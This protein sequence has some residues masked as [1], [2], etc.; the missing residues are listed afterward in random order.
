MAAF[1]QKV[2]RFALSELYPLLVFLSA[3]ACVVLERQDVG[4]CVLVA[5]IAPV[6]FF[7]DDVLPV[8]FPFLILVLLCFVNADQSQALPS[9]VYALVPIVV[10]MIALPIIRA[11]RRLSFGVCFPGL[12]AISVALVLGGIGSITAE[13][14]F[15]L[16]SLYHI[17][18]LGALMIVAYLFVKAAATYERDY[19]A[20]DKIAL[21]SY[22][23]LVFVAFMILRVFTYPDVWEGNIDMTW[24]VVA[25]APWRNSTAALVVTLLPFVFYYA[26][27]HHPIH[28]LCAFLIYVI[29]A[30]SGS[31]GALLCGG[32]Q[33]VLC[34]VFFYL[35]KGT[36]RRVWTWLLASLTVVLLL[37]FAFRDA[38]VQFL[39]EYMRLGV[40]FS[41]V[42][43]DPRLALFWR[44]IEDF[45]ARPIFGR[46]L[47][48]MGNSDLFAP[49]PLAVLIQ[50]YHSLIPQILGSLGLVGA[51]AY[52]YQFVLSIKAILRAERGLYT[53]TLVL[54]YFGLLL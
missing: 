40:D 26:R 36:T 25:R 20:T 5:L 53:T 32:V 18:G 52:L 22:L 24:A 4:L 12:V 23:S 46:G 29:A 49:P 15:S 16:A 31:R 34:L 37:I 50:W 30:L 14:Y 39:E 48:Y 21:F 6:V 9:I 8:F 17:F 41:K 35:R 19:D 38:V 45:M 3:F 10:A 28:I 2:Q 11:R 42:L 54:A 33:F 1:C 13:E 43:T 51:A 27:R 44:G 7:C 47:G